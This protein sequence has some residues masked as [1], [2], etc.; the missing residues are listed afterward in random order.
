ME[1]ENQRV[2]FLDVGHGDSSIIYLNSGHSENENVVIVDIVDSDKLLTE[3]TSHKIKVV[4]LIIIS[5]SDAD[6]CRGVNDFLE[7]YMA[8]GIVKNICF[9][10]DKRQPTKTMKLILKK[11]I[12]IYQKQRITLL[13]GQ[14]DTSVQKRELISND[15]SKLFLI[16]PNV[17]ESTEAYLKNDTNNTSIVCLLENDV[18]NVL[19]SGGDLEE[20]GWQKLIDRIPE[21]R[22]DVLKMPHH[23]AF[24]DEKNGMGLKRILTVLNPKDAIISSGDNQK[25]KHPEEQTIELLKDKQINI[26]CTEFT[27]LCH[28]NLNEFKRKCYGDIEIVITDTTY[29]IRTETDNTS[30]LNHIACHG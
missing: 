5:H 2:K 3:L 18:C 4:D 28:C 9:N 15:K 23:G 6:H 7:K 21:L 20:S 17:A 14:N 25:Y 24:Y 13:M 10:L 19:F 22:C 27:S 26:Y 30:L 29:E 1:S 11:F 8:V 12:E 16:Y